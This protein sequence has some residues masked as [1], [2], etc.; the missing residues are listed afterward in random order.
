MY[1]CITHDAALA[2]RRNADLLAHSWQ[3]KLSTLQ[4]QPSGAAPEFAHCAA[5]S[6]PASPSSAWFIALAEVTI[7]MTRGHVAVVGTV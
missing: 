5:P 3:S 6:P 7:G 4:K 2:D 1:T